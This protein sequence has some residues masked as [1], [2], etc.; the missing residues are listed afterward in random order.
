MTKMFFFWKAQQAFGVPESHRYEG[1]ILTGWTSIFNTKI[2]GFI[3]VSP[4][5]AAS[6][7]FQIA[8]L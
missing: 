7:I 2:G 6:Q 5:S 3:C 8:E 1:K 4:I